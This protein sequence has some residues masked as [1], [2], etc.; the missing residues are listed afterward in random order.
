MKKD[1]LYFESDAEVAE[2]LGIGVQEFLRM[3][4]RGL[5]APTPRPRDAEPVYWK[6]DVEKW[7][8]AGKPVASITRDPSGVGL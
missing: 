1:R 8:E 3:K 2:F 7:I 5:F 6:C 4:S